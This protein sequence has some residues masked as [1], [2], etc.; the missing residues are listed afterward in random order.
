VTDRNRRLLLAKLSALDDAVGL[1]MSKLRE[2]RAED[3][4]LIVF[5]SDNGGPTRELTSSNAPLRGGKG[6]V[7]E[8]GLRVPFLVRWPG[9]IPAGQTYDEPVLSLDVFATAAALAGRP[10]PREQVDG[11]NLVPYLT[12]RSPDRPHSEIF[13]RTGNRTAVRVGDWKLVR[14]PPR[15]STG[16]WELYDL[17][18]DIGEAKNLIDRHPQ[19]AEELQA[20]W[21]R[22]NATMAEPAW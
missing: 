6:D 21:Q 13:W 20:I 8:G 5:L 17:A 19:R 9:T 3:N 22:Y 1:V 18:H 7:Y 16:A 14:N 11:V 12:G 2:H 10:L 15:G 4:T